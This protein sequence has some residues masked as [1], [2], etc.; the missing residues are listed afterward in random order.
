MDE[1]RFVF[2]SYAPDFT[3]GHTAASIRYQHA[4]L[5]RLAARRL[6]V[7]IPVRSGQRT[8]AE[9]EDRFYGVYDYLPGEP[10]RL[11]SDALIDAAASALASMHEATGA[12]VDL[13]RRPGAPRYDELDGLAPE[14]PAVEWLRALAGHSSDGVPIPWEALVEALEQTRLDLRHAGYD[15]HSTVL[16]HGDVN[17]Q[18]LLQEKGRLT[19]ILDLDFCDLASPALDLALAIWQICRVPPDFT[20]FDWDAVDRVVRAYQRRHPIPPDCFEAVPVSIQAWLVRLILWRT[21][22][23]LATGSDDE[24]RRLARGPVGFAVLNGARDKLLRIARHAAT[25]P[26]AR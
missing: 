24:A 19:G 21:R 11:G 10:Y 3:Y 12:V 15:E 13:G 22:G 9:S 1:H 18:N 20:S 2:R 26:A 5:V 17:E 23:L 14:R 6:P 8:F 4:V 25:A 16:I 7:P